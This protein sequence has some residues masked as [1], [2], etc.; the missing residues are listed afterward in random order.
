MADAWQLPDLLTKLGELKA[1][2]YPP[3]A[4]EETAAA[5]MAAAG[6][7]AV[8]DGRRRQWVERK[9]PV[10]APKDRKDKADAGVLDA[11]C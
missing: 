11:A 7:G 4:E 6:G 1:E 2:M 10:P 5:A 8:D 9:G 3:S